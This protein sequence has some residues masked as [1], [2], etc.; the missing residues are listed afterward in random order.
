MKKIGFLSGLFILTIILL[1]HG[2]EKDIKLPVSLLPVISKSISNEATEIRVE[3]SGSS[4]F[5]VRSE[6]PK[7]FFVGTDGNIKYCY[8]GSYN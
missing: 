8:E 3:K 6:N 7:V 4:I 1:Y 2:G 5:P